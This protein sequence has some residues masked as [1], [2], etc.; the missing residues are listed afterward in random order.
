MQP[1][2]NL[3]ADLQDDI[4]VIR[5]VSPDMLDEQSEELRREFSL[6]I[7]EYRPTRVVLDLSRVMMASSAGVSIVISLLRRVKEN[8]GDLVLCCLTPIVQQ[9][10]R[11]CRLIALDDKEG[12][13]QVYPTVESAVAALRAKA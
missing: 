4:L 11:L 13:F 9:V 3:V 10:F 8:G 6:V 5:V 7:K 2:R 1:L 12:V